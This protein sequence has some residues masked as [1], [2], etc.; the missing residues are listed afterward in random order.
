MY[1]HSKL[2]CVDRKLMYVGSE[3]TY[4]SYN[5]DLGGGL[6][7]D[8]NLARWFLQVLLDPVHAAYRQGRGDD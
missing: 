3:K 7:Y 6:N 2:V 5:K 1:S 8:Q 4:P